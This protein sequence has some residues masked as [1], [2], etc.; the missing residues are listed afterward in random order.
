MARRARGGGRGRGR[1]RAGEGGRGRGRGGGSVLLCVGGALWSQQLGAGKQ[2]SLAEGRVQVRLEA[3]GRGGGQP[4][5]RSI[6]RVE[7]A[8]KAAAASNAAAV[9][10]LLVV[11]AEEGEKGLVRQPFPVLLLLLLLLLRCRCLPR[12]LLLAGASVGKRPRRRRAGARR[13]RGAPGDKLEHEP[14]RIRSGGEGAVPQVVVH[15]HHRAGWPGDG[16]DAGRPAGQL[17]T[18]A[19]DVPA[20]VVSSIA[21]AAVELC[22][23]QQLRRAHLGRRVLRIVHDHAPVRLVQPPAAPRQP[24][25][26][27][28]MPHRRLGAALAQVAAAVRVQPV[29]GAQQPREGRDEVRR[30]EEGWPTKRRSGVQQ[31]VARCVAV[32]LPQAVRVPPPGACILRPASLLH[33]ATVDLRRNLCVCGRRHCGRGRQLHKAGDD[34]ALDGLVRAEAICH[35]NGKRWVRFLAPRPRMYSKCPKRGSKEFR[36]RR[37]G[38]FQILG[39]TD[40]QNPVLLPSLVGALS[41][42][43]FLFWDR[44]WNLGLAFMPLCVCVCVC[45]CVCAVLCCVPVHE[46]ERTRHSKV[47]GGSGQR[48]LCK[49]H[50]EAQVDEPLHLLVLACQTTASES[51]GGGGAVGEGAAGAP[52]AA[53]VPP[54]APEAAFPFIPVRS[55]TAAA[56]EATKSSGGGSPTGSRPAVDHPPRPPSRGAVAKARRA[57]PWPPAPQAPPAAA[58]GSRAWRAPPPPAPA[59]PASPPA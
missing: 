36:S 56:S 34:K 9:R 17:L 41:T 53:P 33:A 57:A 8:I 37:P 5:T 2:P 59:S 29:L 55:T 31:V 54:G 4:R 6:G 12:L 47:S 38:D 35:G 50:L 15:H 22:A 44:D 30:L 58:R 42:T 32:E 11:A 39:S 27:V 14:R 3:A 16:V 13:R 7:L 24:F 43:L 1:A 25:V 51:R 20:R 46:R 49:R 40:F 28:D 23:W 26:G 48:R 10:R 19:R 18:E 45:V 52:E 21:V